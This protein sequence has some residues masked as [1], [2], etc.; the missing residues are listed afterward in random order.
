MV[1]SGRAA[2]P[3][4]DSAVR[5][6]GLP[7]G[8][9]AD[10]D[11]AGLIRRRMLA[12][13]RRFEHGHPVEFAVPALWGRF[14]EGPRMLAGR[15]GGRDQGAAQCR[16]ASFG[17]PVTASVAVVVPSLNDDQLIIGCAADKTMLVVDPPGSKAGEIAAQRLG[18][19]DAL[20]RGAPRFLDQA[21]QAA[22]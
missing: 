3:L 18:P 9:L 21:A 11:L 6:S 20:E 1:Q 10:S 4:S 13:R 2:V 16:A 12:V 7:Y 8:R 19:A 17:Q 5:R 14:R 15:A 22:A